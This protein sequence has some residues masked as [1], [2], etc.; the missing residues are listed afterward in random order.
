MAITQELLATCF[1]DSL[2]DDVLTSGDDGIQLEFA[3]ACSQNA[4][5][6]TVVTE[7]VCLHLTLIGPQ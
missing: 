2:P 4:S 1:P 3:R 7:T 5:N 6:N